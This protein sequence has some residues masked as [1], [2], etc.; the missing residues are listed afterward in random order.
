[1]NII[2]SLSSYKGL[3]LKRINAL[4]L[5]ASSLFY[6]KDVYIGE[7][8][9]CQTKDDEKE[10][11][12]HK[13]VALIYKEIAPFK[14]EIL[15]DVETYKKQHTFYLY[16]A[17][18]LLLENLVTIIHWYE[19]ESCYVLEAEENNNKII[20]EQAVSPNRDN[21]DHESH[22]ISNELLFFIKYTNRKP[23]SKLFQ[24]IVDNHIDNGLERAAIIYIIYESVLFNRTLCH[25]W[26]PFYKQFCKDIGWRVTSYKPNRI[27]DTIDDLKR[28]FVWVEEIK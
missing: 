16:D 25:E 23:F 19:D 5:R 21:T 13:L 20:E 26:K 27:K 17:E 18:Y 6:G 2:N 22:I 9:W 12:G 24:T 10:L 1:M 11:Q 7:D 8:D 3:N 28:K 4:Y 14:D 15:S